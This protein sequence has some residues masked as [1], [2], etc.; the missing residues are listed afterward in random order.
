MTG[1]KKCHACDRSP[2]STARTASKDEPRH[3]RQRNEMVFLKQIIIIFRPYGPFL[4][5]Y[6]GS[7][8][9]YIKETSK[10]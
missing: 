8:K 9:V 3:D 10:K 1:F 5:K 7:G 2:N 6:Q 4:H